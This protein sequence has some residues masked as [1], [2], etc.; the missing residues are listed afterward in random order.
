MGCEG[1]I[2]S[3][4]FQFRYSVFYA[5]KGIGLKVNDSLK[6]SSW[7]THRAHHPFWHTYCLLRLWSVLN[8]R[9]VSSLKNNKGLYMQVV[10]TPHFRQTDRLIN[11]PPIGVDPERGLNVS[12]RVFFFLQFLQGRFRFRLFS[13]HFLRISLLSISFFNKHSSMKLFQTVH[14][15]H[16]EWSLVSAANW[17]KYPN[18]NCPHVQHVDVLNRTVDP[19]TGI[20]T[21]ERLITVSQ[22]VPRFISTVNITYYE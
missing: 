16:Y 22:N 10:V 9:L 5:L 18:D 14:D 8:P 4:L 6:C 15:F 2:H 21:T 17:Q 20:L 1:V 19:K 11:E 7:R 12:E 13:F 3:C